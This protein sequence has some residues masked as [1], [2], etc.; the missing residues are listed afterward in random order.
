MPNLINVFHASSSWSKNSAKA[1][2]SQTDEERRAE[3]VRVLQGQIPA[4]ALSESGREG[5]VGEKGDMEWGTCLV[6]SC[7]ADCCREKVGEGK[8][9]WK[10]VK[11][12]W[13]EEFVL[14]Q[15]DI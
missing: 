13:K 9:E 11:A 8:I 14:V 10:E 4:I 12:G 7:L 5:G 15:W 1:K 3:V 6:F 2:K